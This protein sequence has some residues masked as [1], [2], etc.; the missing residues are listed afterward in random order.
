MKTEKKKWE[1]GEGKVE[2]HRGKERA[3]EESGWAEKGRVKQKEID[4]K[5]Y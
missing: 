2:G 3:V 4:D 5:E 1:T